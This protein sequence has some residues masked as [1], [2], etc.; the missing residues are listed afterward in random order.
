MKS[1]L[2]TVV[3]KGG[4]CSGSAAEQTAEPQDVS[5]RMDLDYDTLEPSSLIASG[6]QWAIRPLS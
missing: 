5:H 3:A 1:V 2:S 4:N 6:S